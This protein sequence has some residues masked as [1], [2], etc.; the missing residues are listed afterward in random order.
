M[1]Y[2][3][4]AALAVEPVVAFYFIDKQTRVIEKIIQRFDARERELLDRLMYVTKTP[5]NLPP[6]VESEPA[7]E[8]EPIDTNWRDY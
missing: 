6:R 3:L 1:L 2:L 8:E 5:W 4:I 7:Q